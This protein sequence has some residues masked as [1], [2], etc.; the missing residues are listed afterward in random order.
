MTWFIFSPPP[1]RLAHS[2][3]SHH[4]LFLHTGLGRSVGFAGPNQ[5]KQGGSTCGSGEGQNRGTHTHD[6]TIR[7]YYNLSTSLS[8][9][10]SSLF[11]FL[12]LAKVGTLGDFFFF[13]QILKILTEEE[14]ARH[15]KPQQMMR[16]FNSTKCF[17]AHQQIISLNNKS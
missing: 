10:F 11:I 5:I 1:P 17:A 7:T 16:D 12:F 6:Q 3:S 15:H 2:G 9:I 14:N 8:C 4:V 13:F